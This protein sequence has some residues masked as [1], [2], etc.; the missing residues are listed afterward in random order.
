[1]NAIDLSEKLARI[2]ELW[3]PRI[4]ARVNDTDVKLAKVRGSFEWHAHPDEDELFLVLEGR[5]R[6]EFRDGEVWL[7]KG[8]ACVVPKGV[9]HRPVAPEEVHLLLVEPAG[10]RNT[11]DRVT[12][13]TVEAEW[14]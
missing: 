13:R 14:I 6:I 9:E 1:M 4:V 12:G 10:T 7:G 8:Q 3:S 2:D 5:L 11:G